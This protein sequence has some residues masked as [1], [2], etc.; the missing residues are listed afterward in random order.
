[1]GLAQHAALAQLVEQ[2][3]RKEQVWGSIPQGGSTLFREPNEQSSSVARVGYC[4][5]LEGVRKC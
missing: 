2:L 3:P 5:A 4:L 1:L